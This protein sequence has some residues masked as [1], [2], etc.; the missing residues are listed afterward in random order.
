M[1]KAVSFQMVATLEGIR[2]AEVRGAAMLKSQVH[3]R[4]RDAL[5]EREC[6][7]FVGGVVRTSRQGRALLTGV[8]LGRRSHRRVFA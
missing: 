3:G 4:T 5:L 7:E 8:S 1:V 2:A 6:I